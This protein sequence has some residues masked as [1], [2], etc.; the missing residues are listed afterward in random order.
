MNYK[1]KI[2]KAII[3]LAVLNGCEPWSLILRKEAGYSFYRS[4]HNSQGD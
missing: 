1:I 3:F 2:Y 4:A